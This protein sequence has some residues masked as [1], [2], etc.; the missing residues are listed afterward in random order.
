VPRNAP[1]DQ[2]PAEVRDRPDVVQACSDRGNG[3]LF[4]LVSN[5]TDGPR[6]FTASHIARRCGLSPTRLGEQ[7]KGERR[8]TSAA[9]IVTGRH[10]PN[11]RRARHPRS[12]VPAR[13][14]PWGDSRGAKESP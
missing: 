6:Q 10:R 4:R 5:L 1:P 14:A 7:V 9:V 12:T 2:L 3:H 8:V 13:S 11:R